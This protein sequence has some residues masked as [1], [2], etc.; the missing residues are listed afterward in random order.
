MLKYTKLCQGVLSDIHY[1][2][3]DENDHSPESREGVCSGRKQNMNN[4]FMY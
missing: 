4:R 2:H 1:V 3:F